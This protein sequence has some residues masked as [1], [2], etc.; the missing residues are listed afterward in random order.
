MPKA[1][2][3]P[4]LPGR[5]L[6]LRGPLRQLA[7]VFGSRTKLAEQIGVNERTIHRWSIGA[8]VPSQPTRMMLAALARAHG[9]E[10]PFGTGPECPRPAWLDATDDDAEE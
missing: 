3:P 7:E 1:K 2:G 8:V 5:P 9:L 4:G 6:E 10:P